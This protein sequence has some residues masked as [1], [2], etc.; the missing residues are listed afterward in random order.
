[1]GQWQTVQ[2]RISATKQIYEVVSTLMHHLHFAMSIYR[3]K[4]DRFIANSHHLNN[5]HR[6]S[7]NTPVT[8]RSVYSYYSAL[9]DSQSS[10]QEAQRITQFVIILIRISVE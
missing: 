10:F 4:D 8:L 9:N 7:Q 3:I 5:L 2:K 1:M 6:H